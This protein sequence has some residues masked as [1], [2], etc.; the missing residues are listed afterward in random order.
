[1]ERLWSWLRRDWW[2]LI[3]LLISLVGTLKRDEH[4]YAEPTVAAGLLVAAAV[5][6]LLW[7]GTRPE[8]TVMLTGAAVAVY[9]G[10]TFA[11]GPVYLSVFLS[12]FALASRRPLRDWLP[13]AGTALV[14]IVV[15]QV[16][17]EARVD[18]NS[19]LGSIGWT[20]WF[21]A[22]S[23]A[24]AA[25]GMA[26]RNRRE[27]R[28]EQVRR[29]ATEE[30]LR[31]AQDL[32]DGVGHGLA[33][34]AMQAG[35]ALHVLDRD[36]EA[37]R[38]SL[39][40]IR[41][42]SRESL[43]ALRAELVRLSPTEGTPAPRRPRNGLAD[44]DVLATRV[45]AGGIQVALD[46]DPAVST[47]GDLPIEVDAAAYV[48]VQEALTNVLRHANA[49]SARVVVRRSATALEI[50]VTDDGQETSP[51]TGEGMGIPGM[52]SRVEALGGRLEAGPAPERGFR[53]HAVVPVDEELPT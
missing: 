36:P 50:T 28:A 34:I 46:V 13:Y 6:P 14:A 44:L 25:V 35:V 12:I 3:V 1:V 43:D 30:R 2:V 15:G 21:I 22:V 8:L 51:G 53:V 4:G 5:L 23:A 49:S 40:A 9:F 37:A 47:T 11:D 33:V 29:T 38:H 42:T 10:A 24:A 48:V 26:V 16:V 39:E 27:T 32:H 19:T 18:Q 52:R 20:T 45:R 7:R 41:D 31:M 17:R